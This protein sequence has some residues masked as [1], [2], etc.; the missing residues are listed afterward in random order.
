MSLTATHNRA[1]SKALRSMGGK[2][3]TQLSEISLLDAV[4]VQS[5]LERLSKLGEAKQ[6]GNGLWYPAS[7]SPARP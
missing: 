1:V 6:A 7:D 4:H 2:T 3:I 5:A